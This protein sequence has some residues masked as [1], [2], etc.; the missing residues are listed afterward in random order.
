MTRPRFAGP[1]ALAFLALWFIL[2]AGGRSAFLRDPGTFWHITTGERILAD[3]FIRTDPYTFTFA[4]TWWVPYQW[5]GEVAMALVHRAGGFDAL[6]L[7]AVTII[8]AI[9]AWLFTRLYRTGLHWVAAAAITFFALAASSA[10]FHVRPHLFTILGITITMVALLEVDADRRPIRW[11]WWLVPFYAIW[12]N[13]HGGVLGGMATITI[14]AVGWIIGA[15]LGRPTPV[16]TRRDAGEVLLIAAACCATAFVNPY[17]LDLIRTWQ[18][19]MGE[20]LLR[21]II[22]EHSPLDWRE[23]SAWPIL[24]FALLYLILLAGVPLREL[25]VTWLLPIVWLL[26]SLDRVRHAPLFAVL[27]LAAIASFWPQTR[28]AKR[29]ATTRPDYYDPAGVPPSPLWMNLT[30][31]VLAVA[32]A[33]AL[34]VMKVEVPVIGSGWARH[35]PKHWPMDLLDAIRANEPHDGHNHLFNDYIDGGFIIYYAP[36]YKVFVDDRCEVFGGA[37][38]RDFVIAGSEGT[39][40]AIAKWEAEYGRFEYALTRTGTGF[41]DYF[42]HSP[43]WLCIKRT[44]TAAF[45][46][47]K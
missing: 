39:A 16:R 44:D 22:Q 38:L 2:L 14:T 27:G 1:G 17:G 46:R 47:R 12:V 36:G 25:R 43:D 8:A 11:L 21:E 28:W 15:L 32:L 18:V 5:L 6:L 26:L 20:P 7:G 9:V 34:Q 41:E 30:L 31:P 42:A 37:W 4:G 3:G 33:F 29:L 40:E 24:G 10:H 23:P 13:V 35:D 19:I 45:Y